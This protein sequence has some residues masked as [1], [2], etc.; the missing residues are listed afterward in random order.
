[1]II[2][3]NLAGLHMVK[4]QLS[5]VTRAADIMQYASTQDLHAYAQSSENTL[6]NSSVYGRLSPKHAL[7]ETLRILAEDKRPDANQL[8]D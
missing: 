2:I 4:L 1:M 7:S 3:L 6:L 5:R 8:I